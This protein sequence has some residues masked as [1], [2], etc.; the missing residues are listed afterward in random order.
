MEQTSRQARRVLDHLY[1]ILDAGERGYA[2]AGANVNNRALKMLFKTYARQRA[3]FKAELE[4]QINRLGGAQPSL[5]SIMAMIHRGRINIF[6]ALTIGDE[7]RERVV[8]KEIL[9]GE[10]A[11]LRAYRRALNSG[12]PG[13]L[14]SLVQKQYDAV[15]QVINQVTLMHGKD[16]RQLVVRLYDTDRDARQAVKALEQAHLASSAVDKAA[17]QDETEPYDETKRSTLSETILSGAVGGALWG[18]VSGSLAG[19]GVLQLPTLG[20]QHAPLAIQGMA[21][22]ETA[23]G[24]VLAGGFVGAVLGMFIGWGIHGGDSYL[25][26]ESRRRGQILLKLETDEGKAAQ[27]AQIM[28]QVN[29][30]AHAHGG[31]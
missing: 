3:D 19:F 11:A 20:L 10:R 31:T 12:L 14:E 30:E 18:A 24:A 8:M 16:G 27:A 9:V 5:T 17:V 4:E 28:A 29:R 26:N 13:R 23:L 21:W 15:Q 1:T 2:V 6:A 7:N 25:Y 22:A